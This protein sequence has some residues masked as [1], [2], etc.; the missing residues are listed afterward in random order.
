MKIIAGMK[1]HKMSIA[2][3]VIILEFLGCL[4]LL[5]TLRTGAAVVISRQEG[6]R[7]IPKGQNEE[8]KRLQGTI[9]E[10]MEQ[11]S[12]LVKTTVAKEEYNRLV[13]EKSRLVG[14]VLTMKNA[15][16]ETGKL[17]PTVPM[18]EP[19]QICR[20]IEQLFRKPADETPKTGAAETDMLIAAVSSE[21]SQKGVIDTKQT[22]KYGV[23]IYL[24]QKVLDV[25]GYPINE[26][27]GIKST[28][29][30][31]MKFQGDR[32]LK[33][34]G[35]I[36]QGTWGKVREL[37]TAKKTPG[38]TVLKPQPPQPQPQPQQPQPQ[39]LQSPQQLQRQL[40]PEIRNSSMRRRQPY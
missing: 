22:E 12:A 21:I 8:M 4:I 39:Q 2:I 33:Q 23:G 40:P 3:V 13:N 11:Y 5:Y 31:V 18:N 14:E 10:L 9:N 36:G 34:D 25:V 38:Q 24:I 1:S 35:K 15:A 37:W 19:E 29:D 30:A 27:G 7:F 6:F 28:Y 20:V 17:S 26:S 32:Q 16:V